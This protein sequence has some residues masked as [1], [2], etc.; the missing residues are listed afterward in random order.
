MSSASSSQRPA[1]NLLTHWA[2]VLFMKLTG[3]RVEGQVP[4]AAKLVII[5][6]PHTTNWDF[7]YLLAAAFV[8]RLK[9]HW[10]GKKSLF[11][12]PLG[13]VLKALGGISVERSRSTNLVEA[14]TAKFDAATHLAV[15]I[16]PSGTRGKTE[17]WK[18][19]FYWIAQGA[20]AT[21]LC[22]FLDY[23]RKVAG[24]GYSFEPTG[25]V[26]ADMDA[27][28]EFYADIVGKH[29]ALASTIRL[30]EESVPPG[31]EASDSR[32]SEARTR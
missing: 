14:V 10:L 15:V 30:K 4:D 26:T 18:S 31:G 16:P 32:D 27:V 7:V 2:G 13:F 8:L 20:S 11:A 6:A 12:P 3:W 17:H 28:R 29:P 22:G 21:V 24:L 9:I 19:G 1:G 5:A 23:P 25:N